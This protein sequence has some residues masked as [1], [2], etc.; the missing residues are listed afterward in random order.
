MNHN[1]TNACPGSGWFT[2]RIDPGTKAAC[3]FCG[4]SVLIT[5]RGYVRKHHTN[6][7]NAVFQRRADGRV[8]QICAHGVGHTVFD[9]DSASGV[10]G[11][12]GCCASFDRPY[13]LTVL[14]GLA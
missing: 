14:A 9:P 8:E 10:H 12:D 3:P 1:A 4:K 7:T 13:P 6:A 5:P 2:S 11:C